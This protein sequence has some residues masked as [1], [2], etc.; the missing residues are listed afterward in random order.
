MSRRKTA[1]PAKRTMNLFY[2]PDRTT[3]PATVALYVLFALTCLLGLSKLLVYDLWMETQQAV[4]TRD[5]AEERFLGVM[6][7]LADYNEVQE[8]Y[9]RYSA[10]EE[11]RETIPRMEVLAMLDQ[12]AAGV[13]D[14][15]AV[16]AHALKQLYGMVLEPSL[17]QGDPETFL[18]HSASLLSSFP[19]KIRRVRA[20]LAHASSRLFSR[21]S[22]GESWAVPGVAKSSAAKARDKQAGS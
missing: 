22:Q 16:K 6:A 11:E 1:Y 21:V 13:T 18:R 4:Q 5:A 17:S 2:K 7:E 10:T 14:G 19:S 3:K 9:S 20:P 15:S 8:R 12:A